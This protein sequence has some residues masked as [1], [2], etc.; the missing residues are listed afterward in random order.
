MTDNRKRTLWFVAVFA[1]TLPILVAVFKRNDL[2][3]GTW[4]ES[5]ALAV[6]VAGFVSTVAVRSGAKRR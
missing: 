6:V 5:A 3:V 4:L 1:V 2:N